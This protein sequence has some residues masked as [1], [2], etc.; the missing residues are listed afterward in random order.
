ML[1]EN[2]EFFAEELFWPPYTK[3]A[4][5]VMNMLSKRASGGDSYD[6]QAIIAV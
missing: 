3:V 4:N 5:N 2:P 1:D 6:N